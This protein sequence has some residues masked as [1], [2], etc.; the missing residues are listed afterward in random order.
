MQV[1][2]KEN[3]DNLGIIGDV[4]RVKPGYARNYLIPRGLGAVASED[5]VRQVEHQRK[6]L[7]KKRLAQKAAAEELA[8]K[9]SDQRVTVTRKAGKDGK[10]FGSVSA[11]DVAEKLAAAGFEVDRKLIKINDNLKALGDYDVT[12]R[13]APSIQATIKVTIEAEAE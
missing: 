11:A 13:M 4:V 5:N 9:L 12:V 1:I 10:L 6:Q 8:S 2:L 7:E 3:V